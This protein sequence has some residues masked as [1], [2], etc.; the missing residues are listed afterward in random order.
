M[1]VAQRNINYKYG[2]TIKIK[3]IFDVHYGNVNCDF[4]AFKKFL[5]EDDDP[6]T[7][8]I[9][10]GDLID[11][12]VITDKRYRKGEDSIKGEDIIDQ[13]IEEVYNALLPYK[14][15]ILGLA[16]GNHEDVITKKC[17]TNPIKRLC[18]ELDTTF[19]GYS[20][21][22]KI[23]LNE[24]GSRVRVIVIRLHHGWG[25]GS[26]TRGADITK[27]EK[28]MGKWNADIFFY[29][30]V[31][32]LQYDKMPRLGLCGMKLI[33]KPIILGICGTFIKTYTETSDPTYAEIKGYPPAEIGGLVIKIKP[34]ANSYIIDVES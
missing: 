6:N 30:H 21:L 15:R 8:F 29:G 9:G 33:A 26:R 31:H 3:P 14:E 23:S 16:T 18:K 13:Q 28:D 4:K 2:D 17:G 11:S 7:Y 10:G 27:Y 22:Y 1:I 5:S 32:K 12:I 25:G 24:N 19:L 20:C 34:T